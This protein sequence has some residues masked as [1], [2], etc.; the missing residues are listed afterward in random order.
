MLHP[1]DLALQWAF[2]YTVKLHLGKHL[3][4]CG[5]REDIMCNET[6]I[7][8]NLWLHSDQ[9]L[10][11][12]INGVAACAKTIYCCYHSGHTKHTVH[13]T[14]LF[15]HFNKYIWSQ[16]DELEMLQK[17]GKLNNVQTVISDRHNTE[18]QLK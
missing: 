12:K 13:M 17:V 7:S 10:C 14:T 6:A 4:H 11:H 16:Q 18:Y 8:S 2:W 1:Y 9:G 3:S 15:K 5:C